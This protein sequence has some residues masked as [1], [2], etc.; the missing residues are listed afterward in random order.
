MWTHLKSTQLNRCIL[1]YCVYVELNMRNVNMKTSSLASVMVLETTYS[2]DNICKTICKNQ[3]EIDAV[4]AAI[5]IALNKY[6][7][8]YQNIPVGDANDAI[9]ATKNHLKK[10]NRFLE[11]EGQEAIKRDINE[12]LKK[13]E[14]EHAPTR[15]MIL[16]EAG[17]KM[18]TVMVSE[19]YTIK[20]WR[21]N[22]EFAS[23]MKNA[24][25]EQCE[26]F[27]L[28]KAPCSMD[29]KFKVPNKLRLNYV[30]K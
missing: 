25:K 2:L 8:K 22:R 26:T 30:L 3:N 28:K 1:L 20:E 13:Y 29:I 9:E 27:P 19:F 4:H 5:W 10:T 11:I 16:R 24:F 7:W 17:R 6:Q 15:S 14:K 18:K 21:Y 23:K 12:L